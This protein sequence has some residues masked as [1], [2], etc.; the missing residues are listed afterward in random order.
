MIGRK[1]LPDEEVV[2]CFCPRCKAQREKVNGKFTIIKR[3]KER[4]G[5]ARFF[6]THC[7]TWFNARTGESMEWMG[8]F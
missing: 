2:Y 1:V 8:R 3:G 5:F 4:N 7:K 6:C